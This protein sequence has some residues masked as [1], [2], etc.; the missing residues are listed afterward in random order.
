MK[1]FLKARRDG[2]RRVR[3]GEE[4]SALI[5]FAFSFTI[6][7]TVIFAIMEMGLC[8]YAYNF[9]CEAAREATRY[10]SVRGSACTML[11]NCAI[12]QTQLSDW[13][14]NSHFPGI[15]PSA[16]TVTATGVSGGS[17]SPGNS[18]KVTVTYQFPLAIP[19]SLR[20]TWT[21]RSTS[22]MVISQ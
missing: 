4:G 20:N 17:N 14:K 2:T 18:V 7:S 15:D 13:V 22:Q 21:L 9:V 10:A 1:W 12:T 8:F 11:S 16:V 6:L 19:F 3:A 5:E